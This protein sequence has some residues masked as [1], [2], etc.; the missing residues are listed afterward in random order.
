MNDE[1]LIEPS[2]ALLDNHPEFGEAAGDYANSIDLAALSASPAPSLE[3]DLIAISKA[4][5]EELVADCNGLKE[6]AKTALKDM[7]W[8]GE[9]SNMFF[10][11]CS[12][13]EEVVGRAERAA[14]ALSA[15]LHGASQ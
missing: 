1:E 15:A 2:G 12:Q 14:R 6:A 10:A 4:Q 11:E 9:Q 13:A 8:I 5:V 7:E 3:E